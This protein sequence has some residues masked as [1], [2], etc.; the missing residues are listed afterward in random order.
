MDFA[1]KAS[2]IKGIYQDF[3]A[4]CFNVCVYVVKHLFDVGKGHSHGFIEGHFEVRISGNAV[5][6]S[7]QEGSRSI[8]SMSSS[9]VGIMAVIAINIADDGMDEDFSD[10]KRV[11]LAR[12]L[13]SLEF[14]FVH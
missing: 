4:V 5:R 6:K 12:C 8:S 1:I 11:L 2:V 9:G 7:V 13:S 10:L 14:V 3:A